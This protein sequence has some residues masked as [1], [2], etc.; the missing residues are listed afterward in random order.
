MTK[1]K[2]PHTNTEQNVVPEQTDL[3]TAQRS[4]EDEAEEPTY[5]KMEGAAT[6]MGRSPRKIPGRSPQHKT[7]PE[8]VAHE[9]SVASRVPK[10]PTQGITDRA[11]EESERQKKVVNDRPDAQAGVNHSK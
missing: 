10:R 7:E 11:S 1:Q 8:S 2:S 5:E 6:G 3:E 9:G 4:F